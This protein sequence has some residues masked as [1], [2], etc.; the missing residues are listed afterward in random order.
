MRG[1]QGQRPRCAGAAAA[2]EDRQVRISDDSER[3]R[4]VAIGPSRAG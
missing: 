1:T 3:N 2:D 4:F